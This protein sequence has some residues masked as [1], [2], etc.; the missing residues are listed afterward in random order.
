MNNGQGNFNNRSQGRKN[1]YGGGNS[2]GGSG[3]RSGGSGGS[4][5]SYGGGGS[6]G[7][8]NSHGGSYGGDKINFKTRCND[9]GNDCTVPFRPNGSKPVL[10]SDCFRGN[11]G[12]PLQHERFDDKP[13]F[14]RSFNKPSTEKRPSIGPSLKEEIT[15]I[16]KK[17]ACILAILNKTEPVIS[18][19][20][21]SFDD[22]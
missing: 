5:N 14:K 10:C 15:S 3:S 2:R 16:N 1:S 11:E 6:R 7:G 22:N 18:D 17:L 19:E 12:R 21:I 4:R 8:D 20:S 13:N 9:C